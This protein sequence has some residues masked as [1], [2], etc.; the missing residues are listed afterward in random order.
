VTQIFK[1]FYN[2]ISLK[3]SNMARV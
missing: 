2:A 3:C 1:A